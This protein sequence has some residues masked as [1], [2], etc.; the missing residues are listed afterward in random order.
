MAKKPQPLDKIVISATDAA[1]LIGKSRAWLA[2]LVADGFVRRG[3]N[4]LY[5]PSDVAQGCIR[6]MTDTQ[7][8]ASKT[9]T[10][11]AVQSA[12]AREIELRIARADHEIIDLDEAIGVLDE[13]V[14]GLKADFDGLAASVTRDAALRSLIEG[15]I[16]EIL[17]RAAEGLQQKGRALRSSGTAIDA[18]AEDDTG[19]MGGEESSLPAL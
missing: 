1:K 11:A 14:G 2:K 10:L 4:G 18:D 19:R 9:A 5:K 15:K 13:I 3:S 12:R 8:R 16:D 17:K 6:Y 7:R